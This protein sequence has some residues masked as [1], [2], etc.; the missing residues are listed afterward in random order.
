MSNMLIFSF[1]LLTNLS[2]PPFARSRFWALQDVAVVGRGATF[3]VDHMEQPAVAER[4][5]ERVA[6]RC[7]ERVAAR[8]AVAELG[9]EQ[10]E[11]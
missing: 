7:L 3:N 4:C 2:K 9:N 5:L 1:L 8:T 11:P 6:G 10:L